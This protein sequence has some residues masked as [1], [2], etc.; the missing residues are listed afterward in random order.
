MK[1]LL[2]TSFALATLSLMCVQPVFA[3]TL[4]EAEAN[5]AKM[6]G[7]LTV[8]RTALG[9][10]YVCRVGGKVVL[11]GTATT[12]LATTPVVPRTDLIIGPQTTPHTTPQAAPTQ[13][14]PIT[15]QPKQ[16][17]SGPEV[18]PLTMAECLNLGGTV[19]HDARCPNTTTRSNNGGTLQGTFRCTGVGGH[20][21]CVD[22]S[23]VGNP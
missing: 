15:K 19:T 3:M 22:E 7:Q 2:Q 8:T 1:Y 11:S 5:C 18:M 16:P 20:S 17:G 21:A 14:V 6:K 10:N 4:A 9:V 12:P 13:V 23:N